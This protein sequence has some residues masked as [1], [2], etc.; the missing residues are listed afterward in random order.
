MVGQQLPEIYYSSAMMKRIKGVQNR[1]NRTD[2]Q[3]PEANVMLVELRLTRN[4]YGQFTRY[5][6][7]LYLHSRAITLLAYI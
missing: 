3:H 7:D 5:L 2:T 1:G 4:S 6:R